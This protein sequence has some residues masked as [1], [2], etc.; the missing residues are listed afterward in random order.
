M[1]PVKILFAFICC[2][3][4]LCNALGQ[5]G[6]GT[7]TPNSSAMLEINSNAK[8]LLIPRMTEAQRSG[9]SF[10]ATGLLVYQTDGI[11]GFY[12][13][14]G[15]PGLPNWASLSTSLASEGW[16]LTG[17]IGTNAAN[18]FIGTT[19]AQPFDIRTNSLLKA[20]FTL[21][22]QIE[23]YN[24]GQSVFV[25]ESAGA[26]DDLTNNKNVFIGYQTGE[27]NTTGDRNSVLGFRGLSTNSTGS[28]N[29]AIGYLAL[30][31]NTTGNDNT[32]IGNYAMQSFGNNQTGIRNTAVGHHALYFNTSGE[33]NVAIGYEAMSNNIITGNTIGSYNVAI[34]NSALD[35]NVT[36]NY[37]TGIGN[38]VNVDADNRTNTVVIGG[39]G[40]LS[41]GGDNRVR[42]GNSSMS[43]I[44]GQVGW[45][46]ISDE[47]V[48]ENIKS[49]VK[50]LSFILKLHPV[51]YNYNIDKSNQ[52]QNAKEKI[53][54][55]G[56][57]N[58][59]K[60]RF[61]GFLAQDVAQAANLAGYVFSGIDKPELQPAFGACVMPNL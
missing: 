53:N 15:T 18:N 48:K 26:N 51:T 42:I 32:A 4:C 35:A 21:K 9:I 13:N 27:L 5:V 59:E 34:G 38:N 17:N 20:R 43:S 6:I 54:W 16:N 11:T 2:L 3:I 46:T 57:Y 12:F 23:T 33:Y 58:I 30:G 56:K 14:S 8:G 61:S 52:L 19:D 24:T 47:R 28:E 7:T 44:G 60:I 37:N 29:V 40:N 10:P 1:K 55:N 39:N 22:G 41:L 25:G 49:D 36:G 45:T 31:N 50:G